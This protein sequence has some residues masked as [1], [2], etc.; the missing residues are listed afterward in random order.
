MNSRWVNRSWYDLMASLLHH[1]GDACKHPQNGRNSR[2]WARKD[3]DLKLEYSSRTH[4][5]NPEKCVCV[6]TGVGGWNGDFGNSDRRC[7]Y[8]WNGRQTDRTGRT[9]VTSRPVCKWMNCI[10]ITAK[11]P[12]HMGTIEDFYCLYSPNQPIWFIKMK[13]ILWTL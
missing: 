7:V 9:Q 3:S 5:S 8:G 2:I 11:C 10:P 6:W 4:H 13:P 12:I 1:S